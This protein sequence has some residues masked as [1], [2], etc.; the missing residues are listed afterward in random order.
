MMMVAMLAPVV[1][2][3]SDA[4]K[5]DPKILNVLEKVQ[6]KIRSSD[7]LSYHATWKQE[8]VTSK[9]TPMKYDA[10][11]W[12]K[13]VPEDK[14][15]GAYFHIQGTDE[16]G[17]FDYYFDGSAGYEVRDGNKKVILYRV[18]DFPN[19][20]GHPAKCMSSA[21]MF[22]L[23]RMVFDTNLV[24]T[25][26]AD[27]GQITMK[28]NPDK[29]AW[30]IRV[31]Y[32]LNKL[33]QNKTTLT[34]DKQTDRITHVLKRAVW[35]GVVTQ[36][37]SRYSDYEQKKSAVVPHIFMSADAKSN[38]THEIFKR[39][40]KHGTPASAKLIGKPA[41]DFNYTS[42]S[43]KTISKQKLE[44]KVV[45]LDFWESWC[46]HCR[47][48]FPDINQ[49]QKRW[50]NDVTVIGVVSEHKREVEK[51]LENSNLSY[52]TI[53]AD[54]RMV[55]N[56]GVNGVPMYVLIDRDGKVVTVSY[57]DL[58]KIKTALKKLMKKPA[59][60]QGKPRTFI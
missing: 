15:L 59:A 57:G 40:R 1:L 4:P 16:Q 19:D 55:K 12:E 47:I 44:G 58:S 3:A 50:K 41:P 5:V 33:G 54:K 43:G 10:T 56:Y 26:L 34:I 29:N 38:Y 11:I 49:L 60:R 7:Y 27:H 24:K 14:F 9:K 13:R 18:G 45:V 23:T 21:I 2:A 25:V 46:G 42:F 28:E 52:R 32:K 30:V 17:P 8:E 31:V 20:M 6:A 36:I 53:Y 35:H 39:T 48:S 37:D 51:I 22:Y